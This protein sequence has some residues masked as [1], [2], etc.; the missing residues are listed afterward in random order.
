MWAT[1]LSSLPVILI[2]QDIRPSSLHSTDLGP[3]LFQT[4]VQKWQVID[5]EDTSIDKSK[6]VHIEVSGPAPISLHFNAGSKDTAEA[7]IAKLSSSRALSA[8][9]RPSVSSQREVSPQ[10]NMTPSKSK[11]GVSVHFDSTS[12]TIIPRSP[13]EEGY[14]EP[15][16]EIE[17]EEEEAVADYSAP[18]EEGEI[19]EAVYDFDAA[20]EDELSVKEGER[21]VVLE[22]DGDE[23][24]K[25]RN[26][27]GVEGVVPASYLEVCYFFCFP[28]L[29]P[30]MQSLVHR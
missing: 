25:C 13:S 2:R 5:I 22:R 23:W 14:P 19:A 27:E 11:N 21:L 10:P 28:R 4:P 12:P 7:I 18:A 9:P 8:V 24:W 20:G 6:H 3:S 26:S 17:P 1:A 29:A 15:E 30:H 16:A